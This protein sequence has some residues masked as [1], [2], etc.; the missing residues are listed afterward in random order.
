VPEFVHSGPDKKQYVREMFDDISPRYDFLNHLL[1]FG[2]DYYWRRK[3]VNALPSDLSRPV[4]DVATGT[5]DVGIAIKKRHSNVVVVGLDYAF[6][7]TCLCQSKIQSRKVEGFVVLQGDGEVLPF[8]D[9]RFS[10]LTI[11]FGFRNI[12]HY[13]RALAEFHRVLIPGGKL[14][15]LEFAEPTSKTL[16]TLYRFY[17]KHIL[18]RI[19][20]LFSRSFRCLSVFAGVGRAFPPPGG[21]DQFIANVGI[22]ERIDRKPDFWDGYFGNRREKLIR[23]N[24]GD[25]IILSERMFLIADFSLQ[26]RSA[27][28]DCRIKVF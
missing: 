6:R 1:S 8:P 19:G 25:D 21:I 14:L 27:W 13:R 24:G 9:N 22:Q 16:G 18:P 7:M 28:A 17:F 5:G 12:G 3:L 11:A 10:A 20:A 26:G 2:V 15:I 23:I 4:L